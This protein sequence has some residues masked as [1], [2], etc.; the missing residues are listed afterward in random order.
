MTSDVHS[1]RE[2]EYRPSVGSILQKVENRML[3][4]LDI[5][6]H[7]F[8]NRHLDQLRINE[9]GRSDYNFNDSLTNPDFVDN[10]EIS[11]DDTDENNIIEPVRRED[12]RDLQANRDVIINTQ[13]DIRHVADVVTDSF[14]L[15]I[16]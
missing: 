2:N 13:G 10:S 1:Y 16:V 7:S 12:C 14:Y 3:K 8:H 15:C 9:V 4:I 6:D 11:P 5:E